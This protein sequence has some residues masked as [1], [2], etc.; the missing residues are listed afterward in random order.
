MKDNKK[1]HKKE[2]FFR[3]ERK[4]IID[5]NFI[6]SLENLIS[7]TSINLYEK[8]EE[9]L[10]NSI[11][12]DD[13]N[14][15][16]ARNSIDGILSRC[17]VRIR[18]YGILSNFISPKLEIK[19]KF[20]K[21]GKKYIFNINKEELYKHNFLISFLK[22]IENYTYFKYDFIQMLKPKLIV[23]YKRKY[24]VSSC[25]LFRFTI[26]SDINFKIF[27]ET[28]IKYSL[29]NKNYLCLNRNILE[30]KYGINDEIKASQL[31]N[32]IP[33]RLTSSSKYIMGLNYLGLIN[34]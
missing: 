21:V 6:N 13:N 26:D 2:D 19:T 14:F 9:R 22:K 27:D 23:S 20:G 32:N 7:F 3:Y 24:F 10:V 18:T 28:N 25:N 1:K 30:L 29:K 31:L 4:F 17:K 15:S 33:A 34:K 12:Y 8:Y 16:L 5:R 11:Y